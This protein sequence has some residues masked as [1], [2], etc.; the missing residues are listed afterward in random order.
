MSLAADA[1]DVAAAYLDTGN[2]QRA[3]EVL[4][5]AL[6]GDP[7]NTVL[8]AR[9]AQARLGLKDY[10]GAASAAYS[11]LGVAPTNAYAKRVYALALH[12][13]GRYHE[14]RW[15]AW[16]TVTEHPDD[17]RAHYIYAHLLHLAGFDHDAFLVINEAVRL[18]PASA[19]V[20]VLRG[21][22]SRLMWNRSAAEADYHE[23]LRLEPDNASAV[24]NLAVSRLRWGSLTTAVRGFL[25]A[26]RLDPELGPLARKNI[27]AVLIRVL[28]LATA[29]VVFLAVALIAMGGT[30][31]LHHSTVLPRV[32]AV[33][34]SAGLGAV[35]VWVV[36][37]VPRPTL[38]TVLRQRFLL[39]IRLAFL[40]VA[41]AIGI[42]T[43]LIGAASVAG[44]LG[45]VLL[46]GVI[47]LTVLGW[48]VGQ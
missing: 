1:G 22:I 29:S 20:R 44:V 36:R 8:L 3:A 11:A 30:H 4:Q 32:F 26:G 13:L 47:G 18:N 19:D 14:A 28:R 5:S 23:A 10:A 7:G 40:M 39:V 41:M 38:R 27:G 46:L 43:A 12:G 9:Y 24:H 35:V 15:M 16:R 45:P 6:A 17:Y 21:D 25:G 37:S 33:V 2:Y 34:L 31:D 48:L 42:G